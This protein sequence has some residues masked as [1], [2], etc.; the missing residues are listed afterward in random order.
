MN[1]RFTAAQVSS[2]NPLT[3]QCRCGATVQLNRITQPDERDFIH[4]HDIPQAMRPYTTLET[5]TCPRCGWLWQSETLGIG[6]VLMFLAGPTA[7]P[8]DEGIP[9]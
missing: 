9:V 6:D 5:V 4:G 3:L 7:T 1:Y 2:D 8:F